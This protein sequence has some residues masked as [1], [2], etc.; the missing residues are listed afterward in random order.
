MTGSRHAIQDVL[1]TPLSRRQVLGLAAAS[2]LM[3]TLGGCSDRHEPAA[4]R[5]FWVEI[6]RAAQ[7][8]DPTLTA[9]RARRDLG[10]FSASTVSERPSASIRQTLTSQ[11]SED[12]AA[13]RTVLVTGW[14]LS[15]TEVLLSVIVAEDQG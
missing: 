10:R 12:Y 15:R 8:A 7:A 4:L 13:A 11:I 3:G 2:V 9:E 1:A 6:A 5:S 14:L